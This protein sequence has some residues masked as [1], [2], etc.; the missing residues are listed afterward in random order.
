MDKNTKITIAAVAA[1]GVIVIF[2]PLLTDQLRAWRDAPDAFERLDQQI[3]DLD[4]LM[5]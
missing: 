2:G 4:R 1:I 5:N 3:D